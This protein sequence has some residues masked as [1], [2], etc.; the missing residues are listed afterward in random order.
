M[1]MALPDMITTENVSKELV[2]A[3]F[4][5]AFIDTEIDSDGDL[6]VKP[7]RF[8]CWIFVPDSKNFVRLF[9]GFRMND[10]ASQ[11]AKLEFTNKVNDMYILVRAFLTRTGRVQFDYYLPIGEGLHPKTLI[12]TARRFMDVVAE[13]VRDE[14]R[15]NI[16]S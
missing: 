12:L 4:E 6:I 13:A 7:T 16:F 5:A 1:A 9:T 2:Q 8:N 10:D 15:D 14:D 3:I 11:E